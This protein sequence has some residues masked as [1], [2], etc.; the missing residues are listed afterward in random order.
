MEQVGFG[1]NWNGFKW[2][3]AAHLAKAKQ[4]K[5]KSPEK[6]K[7]KQKKN[8]PCLTLFRKGT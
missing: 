3:Q 5:N 4:L 7:R 6:S 1:P 8:R 2:R